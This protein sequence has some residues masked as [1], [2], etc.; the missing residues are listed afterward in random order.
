MFPNTQVYDVAVK[1]LYGCHLVHDW[2]DPTV[3][4]S[5]STDLCWCCHKAHD[6]SR[7]QLLA[8]ES[9]LFISCPQK[10]QV[11]SPPWYSSQYRA[12]KTCLKWL[13]WLLGA[14]VPTPACCWMQ[15]GVPVAPDG[16]FWCHSSPGSLCLALHFARSVHPEWPME[17][18]LNKAFV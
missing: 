3:V 2:R 5:T 17:T 16:L 7:R 12:M 18:M 10:R 14:A 15:V 8:S 11:F 4:L 6:G 1:D 9:T 13:E